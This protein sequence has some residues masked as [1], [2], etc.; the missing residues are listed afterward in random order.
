M[1][2]L[3]GCCRM[4]NFITTGLCVISLCIHGNAVATWSG[5]YRLPLHI[6]PRIT[7]IL[8]E[9]H[10]TNSLKYVFR[11]SGYV[12]ETLHVWVENTMPSLG[13]KY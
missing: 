10:P 9:L 6:S 2:G 13:R 8:H 11:A 1:N 5:V 4:P 7:V 12:T 3:G